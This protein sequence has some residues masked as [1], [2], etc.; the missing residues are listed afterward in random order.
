MLFA[1][2]IIHN[3]GLTYIFGYWSKKMQALIQYRSLSG[4]ID[5]LL[6]HASHVLVT[7]KQEGE[8]V[9]YGIS[10]LYKQ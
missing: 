4:P 1:L 7:E 6:E 3:K 9:A 10:D 5:E 2:Y 8:K